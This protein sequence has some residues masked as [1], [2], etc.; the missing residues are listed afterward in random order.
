M[1]EHLQRALQRVDELPEAVQEEIALHIEE[2]LLPE[3]ADKVP[4]TFAG[5]WADLQ[6]DDEFAYL[7][8]I[9]HEVPPTP[10]IEDE[11]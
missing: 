1:I 8:R 7:D 3:P 4:P 9:R 11:A 5:M 6:G 2:I 10:P